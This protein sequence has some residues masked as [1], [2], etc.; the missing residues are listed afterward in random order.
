M[1]W[2]TKIVDEIEA[3]R[4]EGEVLVESGVS[5]SGKYHLGTL[6]EVLTA[7]AL[8][9]EL[10]RRGRESRHI[11]FVD[12]LD[13]LRK[14]PAGLPDD[15]EKYLGKPLCDVPAPDNSAQS[16]ADYF[17]GDLLQ[18]AEK[19]KLG[20]D[21]DRSHKR[22][23]EGFFVPA[24]E[25]ALERTDS[26]REI[27]ETIS[28][29]KLGEEWSPIQVNE[30][31][32]LKKRHF[33]GIDKR[34][35]T[36]SYKDR[37]GAQQSISYAGGDVK[38]DW[39]IDW[40][41]RWWLLKIDAEPF[42]RDHATKGGSYDTGAALSAKVFDA[43][44]PIALPYA[45]INRSGETKKMSKSA[46]DTVDLA[47]LLQILPPEVV[48]YFVIRYSPDKQLFFDEGEGVVRLVDEFAELLAKPDKTPEDEQLLALCT[49]NL[50]V[51]VSKVPFSHLAASYQAAR[52]DEQRTLKILSRT[53]FQD[54]VDQQ[55]ETVKREL[56]YIG[57]WL[58]NWAPDS[59]KFNIEEKPQYFSQ[60]SPTDRKILSELADKI[61]AAPQNA[62]G[63]W[64]HKAI[65]EIKETTN[66]K[67]EQVFKPL[68]KVLINK[69][70]GPRAGHFLADLEADSG[71]EW[72]IKRLRLE[73]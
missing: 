4:P 14:I 59:L 56:G 53:G 18:A 70:Y 58:D 66:I 15:F 3:R 31:G 69:D 73:A 25:K 26:V 46:G 38:L 24:I 47:Q 2:L 63:E 22:Y 39:R 6:R 42:G 62:D 48:W 11:H 54:V 51:S 30:D 71:R 16:Y 27:L 17:L 60:L 43:E 35:K 68:Y 64:F 5:P 13:G 57:N 67:P 21:V 19:L 41:A 10:R 32:Y 7:E 44:P 72:L 55:T 40:P 23:R 49:Q 9:R 29:H 65:Y 52:H 36:V 28:G 1:F 20:M 12:D 61:A 37:G 45:F 33:I 8:M 34:A 50:T